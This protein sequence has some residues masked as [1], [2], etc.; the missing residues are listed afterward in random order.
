MVES[1]CGILCSEYKKNMKCGD[2]IGCIDTDNPCW[3]EC[4][5]KKCCENKKLEHCGLCDNFPCDEL[6][7]MSYSESEGDNGKRVE[8]C[9]KWACIK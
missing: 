8:Q 1:R 5:I 7:S 9:Q 6:V 2:C 4:D 3:G